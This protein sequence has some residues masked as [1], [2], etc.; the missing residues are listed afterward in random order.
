MFR[1]VLDIQ[2][3]LLVISGICLAIRFIYTEEL[4]IQINGYAVNTLEL[5]IQTIVIVSIYRSMGWKTSSNNNKKSLK[6]KF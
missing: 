2:N 5:L 4:Y 3:D 1:K 6:N